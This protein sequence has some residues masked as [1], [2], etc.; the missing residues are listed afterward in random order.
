[1]LD[2]AAT[3]FASIVI[4]GTGFGLGGY[5]YHKFYKWLVIYKMER[6]FK[7]GDPVL[8]LAAIGKQ[9]PNTIAA[10]QYQ[11]GDDHWI[12][13][14]EQVKIDSIVNGTD[15]GRY[16]LLIGEKGTGKSSMLLDAMQKV[17]GE[18]CSMFEAHA[19]LEIFRV[20]LGKALDLS[21]MRTTSDH[22]S[23]REGQETARPCWTS[24]VLSTSWRKL[25]S[26]DGEQSASH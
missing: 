2:A 17:D 23:P 1:M 11:E 10:G 5:L 18:G 24:S 19:D 21:F 20:R 3:A 4:L 26:K 7:P 9:M 22:I 13:R 8:E 16:H 15:H 6:A 12:L 14:D 25:L